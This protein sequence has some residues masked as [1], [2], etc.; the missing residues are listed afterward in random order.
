MSNLTIWAI[1]ISIGVSVL[2]VIILF[3]VKNSIIDILDKDIIMY[4]KNFEIKRNAI[5]YALKLIDEIYTKGQAITL[6]ANF[7]KQARLCYNELLCIITNIKVADEFYYLTLD[8]EQIVSN[9][10]LTHFKLMCRQDLGL[11]T[12]STKAIKQANSPKRMENELLLK[13]A[14]LNQ[15]DDKHQVLEATASMP[16]PKKTKST[17]QNKTAK[18]QK[19]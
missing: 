18:T 8:K 14:M 4:D 12:K 10:R 5:C 3:V 13:E 15:E 7:E 9:S 11:N 1:C 2:S 16:K 6:N 17:T 19:K